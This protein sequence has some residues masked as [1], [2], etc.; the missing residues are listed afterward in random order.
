MVAPTRDEIR[1][2]ILEDDGDSDDI[3][4][5]P[6]SSGPSSVYCYHAR[7]T[8]Y[9]VRHDTECETVT[10]EQAQQNGKA[11]CKVCVLED[12]AD[13]GQS[14]SDLLTEMTPEEAGLTPTPPPPDSSSSSSSS[15]PEPTNRSSE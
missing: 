7:R 12:I 4:Y 15:P 13:C 1:Q 14:A 5:L 11:P 9:T 8:C 2:R 3:V 6:V 10:R